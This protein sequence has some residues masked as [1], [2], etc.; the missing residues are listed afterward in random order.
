MRLIYKGTRALGNTSNIVDDLHSA[1][2]IYAAEVQKRD[3]KILKGDLI[4][5]TK[6]HLET[7]ASPNLMDLNSI[8]DRQ[9]VMGTILTL[10]KQQLRPYVS[11]VELAGIVE[12]ARTLATNAFVALPES[13]QKSEREWEQA[14]ATVIDKAMLI[15]YRQLPDDQQ[16]VVKD[17]VYKQ[18]QY[19]HKMSVGGLV[20]PVNTSASP[21]A[22]VMMVGG[23]GIA[24]GLSLLIL[25]R[26]Q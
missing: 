26:R 18:L 7:K 16:I 8:Q 6:T 17:A 15:T 11:A 12:H 2:L 19:E 5:A 14:A 25:G 13:V 24:I 10:I 20:T 9:D 1:G 23:L 3:P 22:K 4:S 21:L